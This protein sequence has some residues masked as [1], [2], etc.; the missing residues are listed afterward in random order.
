MF[1]I[2]RPSKLILISGPT[3]CGKSTCLRLL[4]AS[5]NINIIEWETRTT[6]SLTS[7]ALDE[8]RG[9]LTKPIEYS[10][11]ISF[12][13]IDNGSNLKSVLFVHLC[14]NPLVIYHPQPGIT[15]MV[16]SSKMR[17]K[18]QLNLNLHLLQNK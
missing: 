2:Q 9:S 3:G 11:H 16:L 6:S 10:S 5:L 18:I 1:L 8:Q 15:P 14:F 7:T 17:M 12:Q 13:R 4:A